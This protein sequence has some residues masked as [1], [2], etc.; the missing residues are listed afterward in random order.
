MAGLNAWSLCLSLNLPL[1]RW[2]SVRNQNGEGNRQTP[3]EMEHVPVSGPHISQYSC[4]TP[5]QTLSAHFTINGTIDENR[6]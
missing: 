3:Q 2:R 1:P 6:I 5:I 4:L